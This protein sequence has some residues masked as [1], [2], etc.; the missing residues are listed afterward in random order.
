MAPATSRILILYG[1]TDGQTAKVA[2][3]MA[4]TLRRLHLDVDV[5]NAAASAGDV[6]AEEYGAV[7]VAA[8]VQAGKYQRTVTR[9]V[10]ENAAAL[11]GRPSAF[12]SVC[13]AA[14]QHKPE[15]VRDIE[16]RL[17]AWFAGSG[18]HPEMYRAI[19]GA[20]PYTRY[21]WWKRY[22]MRRIVAKANGDTDTTRD[23]EYTD[24][25]DLAAF[26]SAFAR[27]AAL[28]PRGD[29]ERLAS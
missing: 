5:V 6:R 12:I 14:L 23:Y 25:A 26:V 29:D 27:R 16:A 17:Q 19:A 18:W 8:S 15:V 2:S 9:W 1:T 7:I 20:L 13:L 3:A 22:M 4:E 11:N 10:R 24:W 21:P 28:T